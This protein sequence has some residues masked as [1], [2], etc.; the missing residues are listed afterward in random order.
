MITSY[1]GNIIF[2]S[3]VFVIV[4]LVFVMVIL[5]VLQVIV[6]HRLH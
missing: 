3:L 2:I 1:F 6:W 4:S 5:V